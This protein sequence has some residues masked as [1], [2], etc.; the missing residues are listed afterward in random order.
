MKDEDEFGFVWMFISES[1]KLH[2]GITL[3]YSR[4][5]AEEWILEHKMNKSIYSHSEINSDKYTTCFNDNIR[6]YKQLVTMR[7]GQAS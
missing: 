2:K 7:W 5:E 6:G 3:D 1:I 4:A